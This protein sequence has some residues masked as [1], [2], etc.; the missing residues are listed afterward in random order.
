MIR[1]DT[2]S[3][4]DIWCLF[5]DC[6]VRQHTVAGG[7]RFD[8]VELYYAV[9][10]NGTSSKLWTFLP[11]LRNNP[12]S[13][14][15]PCSVTYVHLLVVI[16]VAS[17]VQSFYPLSILCFWRVHHLNLKFLS[18]QLYLTQLNSMKRCFTINF[19]ITLVALTKNLTF[20]ASLDNITSRIRSN[21]CR[22]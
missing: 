6:P 17:N 5:K 11:E 15:D 4:G 16:F 12:W 14:V 10:C 3:C 19:G 1:A 13:N 7:L 21:D 9:P 8:W 2:K 22:K 18:T 20:D